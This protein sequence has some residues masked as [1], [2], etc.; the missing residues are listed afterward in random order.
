M[1]SGASET[2]FILTPLISWGHRQGHKSYLFFAD[3]TNT[4]G[5]LST[6]VTSGHAMD[7]VRRAMLLSKR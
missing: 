7:R 4:L 1:R 3:L 2:R 5:C 6:V